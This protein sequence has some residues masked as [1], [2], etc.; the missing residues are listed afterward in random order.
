MPNIPS[1]WLKCTEKNVAALRDIFLKQREK[2]QK[3]D[4]FAAAAEWQPSEMS[5]WLNHGTPQPIES[6]YFKLLGFVADS[7]WIPP[8]DYDQVFFGISRFLEYPL[9]DLTSQFKKCE[10][11]YV[12]YRFSYLAPGYIL[13]G[14]LHVEYNNVIKALQTTEQCRIQGEI[15]SDAD[16]NETDG[17][18]TKGED[19][20]FPRTGYLFPR[21]TD[22]FVLISKK[23]NVHPVQL[24]T[25][26]FDNAYGGSRAHEHRD[27]GLM[28][29]LVTDWHGKTFYTTRIAAQKL[30][31][32]LP[33]DKIATVALGQINPVIRGYLTT[34]I[35]NR[36][37][38]LWSFP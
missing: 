10:G 36:Y 5:K 1:S 31:S 14:S 30:I 20:H 35:P 23:T 18:K 21:G 17:I 19:L 32:P 25:V 37:K 15:F 9:D 38:Y 6:R 27:P 33:E 2:G 16:S 11:D 28:Y 22:S 13:R 7:G 29:G 8:E 12:Y 3:Q 26:Y 4:G 24:Q 34:P